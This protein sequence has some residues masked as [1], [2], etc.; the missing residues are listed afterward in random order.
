MYDIGFE[1]C[2]KDS[3]AM[4]IETDIM[5]DDTLVQPQFIIYRPLPPTYK[6]RTH[7]ANGRHTMNSRINVAQKEIL[8]SFVQQLSE[9]DSQHL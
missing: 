6:H 5:K 2:G 8:L 4:E 9:Q 7:I 1:I 3:K